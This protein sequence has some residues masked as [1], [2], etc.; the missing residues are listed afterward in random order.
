MA[1]QILELCDKKPMS[2]V[3]LYYSMKI[4]Y[5]TINRTLKAMLTLEWLREAKKDGSRVFKS[6]YYHEMVGKDIS[7]LEV[8]MVKIDLKD[9]YY[10]PT[11]LGQEVLK[12][13]R[14]LVDIQLEVDK[15]YLQEIQLK[16]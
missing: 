15:V 9:Y 8:K 16:L 12:T 10:V 6:R 13:W 4:N 11:S 14:H 2:M 1:I 5:P 3:D 7:Q